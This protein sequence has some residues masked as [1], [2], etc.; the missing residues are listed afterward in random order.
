MSVCFIT[1][2]VV[3][4]IFLTSHLQLFCVYRN[5]VGVCILTSYLNTLLNLLVLGFL[6]AYFMGFSM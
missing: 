1:F 6:F 5:T 4:G 2:D 3:N